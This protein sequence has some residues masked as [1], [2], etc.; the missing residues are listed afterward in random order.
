RDRGGLIGVA[1]AELRMRRNLDFEVGGDKGNFLALLAQQDI[2]QN[3]QR[4]SSFDYSRHRGQRFQQGVASRLYELHGYPFKV[5]SNTC[6]AWLSSDCL[7]RASDILRTACSTV[8][9]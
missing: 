1:Q 4:I 6:K 8:V 3:G 9:D 7:E 2:G 5:C